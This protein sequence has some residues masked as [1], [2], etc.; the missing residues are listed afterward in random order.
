[1]TI[2][3]VRPG[4]IISSALINFMLDKLEELESRLEAPSTGDIQIERFEP[5]NGTPV[6]ERLSIIGRNFVFP[7]EE[8]VVEIANVLV[9]QF[10]APSTS[11]ILTF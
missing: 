10:E 8:N 4:E 5:P 3:R 11:S 1:M 6:G 9:T 7:A 2:G